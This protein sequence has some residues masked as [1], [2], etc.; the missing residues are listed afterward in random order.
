MVLYN[1]IEL[2][3]NSCSLITLTLVLIFMYEHLYLHLAKLTE[4]LCDQLAS[5]DLNAKNCIC[6][7]SI[8]IEQTTPMPEQ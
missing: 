2:E 3:L 4:N 7:D 6:S 5:K 1:R 8:N